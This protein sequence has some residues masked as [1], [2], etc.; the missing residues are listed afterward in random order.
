MLL[1]WSCLLSY[2]TL[3]GDLW[4]VAVAWPCLLRKPTNQGKTSLSTSKL[5]ERKRLIKELYVIK[6]T[7]NAKRKITKK[8]ITLYLTKASLKVTHYKKAL[9]KSKGS[10]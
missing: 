8:N 10:I 5:L 2:P 3:P 6:R 1:S 7:I 9:L 4:R